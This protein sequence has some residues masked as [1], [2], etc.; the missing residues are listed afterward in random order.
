M[1][2]YFASK[3]GEISNREIEHAEAVRELAG[4][5]MVLL[6]NDGVLPL[7]RI[8]GN[9]AATKLIALT[10]TGEVLGDISAPLFSVDK[11]AMFNGNCRMVQ[12]KMSID[13][14]SDYLSV[15]SEKIMQ[16]VSTGEIPAEKSGGSLLFDHKEV[17]AWLGQND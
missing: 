1:A 12:K 4:Q 17:Q 2:Q 5:C 15:D 16:W 8:K 9:I 11:G 14:L 6:E 7:T 10:S 13:E 3:C